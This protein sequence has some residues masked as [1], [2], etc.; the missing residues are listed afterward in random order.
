MKLFNKRV[1]EIVVSGLCLA[2]LFFLIAFENKEDNQQRCQSIVVNI[3]A[4]DSGS[5]FV[6]EEQVINSMTKSGDEPLIGKQLASI[7][8]C[9]LENK[10]SEIP[11]VKECEVYGDLKG[12][13]HVNIEQYTPIARI[14]KSNQKD[15]YLTE[16]G[17]TFPICDQYTSRVLLLSGDYFRNKTSL[18]NSPLIEFV[19][20]SIV[21]KML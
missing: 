8:L 5:S 4:N 17:E 15:L 6:N 2:T 19:N 20:H 1:V 12:N 14:L 9:N 10:V 18:L 11:Q 7:D 3:E 13:I 21:Q 16:E